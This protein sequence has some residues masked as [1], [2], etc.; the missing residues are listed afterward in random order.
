MFVNCLQFHIT[1]YKHNLVE[2]SKKFWNYKQRQETT[3]IYVV[4]KF[5]L[6]K[7]GVLELK[8]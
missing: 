6:L 4:T 1:L 7:D 8:I 5:D 2:A 3:P